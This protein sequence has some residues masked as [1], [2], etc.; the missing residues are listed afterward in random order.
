MNLEA[1]E[2]VFKAACRKSLKEGLS[3]ARKEPSIQPWTYQLSPLQM[4][5]MTAQSEEEY[6]K[7]H[8]PLMS[9]VPAGRGQGWETETHEGVPKLACYLGMQPPTLC[10]AQH[11]SGQGILLFFP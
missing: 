3:R 8:V 6:H 9:L 2:V 7:V 5:Q 11:S 10:K 4:G 1:W